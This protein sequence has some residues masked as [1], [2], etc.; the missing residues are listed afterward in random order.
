MDEIRPPFKKPGEKGIDLEKR[1]KKIKPEIKSEKE[2]PISIA[3]EKIKKPKMLATDSGLAI[4]VI[5]SI[6]IFGSIWYFLYRGAFNVSSVISRK[7]PLPHKETANENKAFSEKIEKATDTTEWKK[8]TLS[9]DEGNFT[10]KI[11]RGWQA[12]ISKSSN[13]DPRFEALLDPDYITAS[14][15]SVNANLNANQNLNLSTISLPTVSILVITMKQTYQDTLNSY[16]KTKNERPAGTKWIENSYT[17]STKKGQKYTYGSENKNYDIIDIV[18]PLTSRNAK[19]LIIRLVDSSK[20]ADIF[21][22]MLT[23]FQFK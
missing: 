16:T 11:P 18:V 10:F 6:L 2:E 1:R 9:K 12:R 20:N 7:I 4:I 22:A 8:Y 23:T 3:E 13:S 21:E 14:K 19:T 5:I 17:L 15:T